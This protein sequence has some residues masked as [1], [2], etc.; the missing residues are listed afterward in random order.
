MPNIPVPAFP[1]TLEAF[2]TRFPEFKSADTALVMANLNDAALMIDSGVWGVQAAVGHGFLTAHRL[3]LSPFG[4]QAR[5]V[6]SDK[7]GGAP[8]TTYKA[9]YDELCRIVGSGFRVL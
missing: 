7:K 9:H 6:L 8:K 5:L 1:L 2:L 3:A 4:Q